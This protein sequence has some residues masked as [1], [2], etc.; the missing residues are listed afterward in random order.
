M[1]MGNPATLGSRKRGLQ[2]ATAAGSAVLLNQF[3]AY[4]SLEEASG[5]RVDSRGGNNLTDV[6]TVGQAVGK[7]A[8]AA[9]FVIA[10]S[11]YLDLADS[12]ALSVG[13]IDFEFSVWVYLDSKA[14]F[15]TVFSKWDS[16]SLEYLLVYDNGADRF[17]W[18]TRLADNSSTVTVS[19]NTFGAVSA[20]TWYHIHVYHDATN[21][22]I[23]I[24]VNNGAFD[25]AA[26]AGGVLDATA[27]FRVGRY[28][29]PAY[30]GGR[31][32]ELGFWKRLLTM[33]E[34]TWIYNGGNGRSYAEIL[35]YT[36]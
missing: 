7:V 29:S 20:A 23:G 19:S 16:P 22:L 6:N 13:D 2:M 31:V 26:N 9:Q 1:K 8:N 4:Y 12:P 21:D 15:Q 3:I 11:E 24:N 18:F 32:D 28:E 30:L 36:G 34:R 10:N 27:P 17:T 33:A 25:T 5:T 35:A 14:A